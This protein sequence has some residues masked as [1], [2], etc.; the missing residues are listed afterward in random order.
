MKRERVSP[1]ALLIA[2]SLALLDSEPA[3]EG[4]MPP[5][6]GEWSRRFIAAVEG[7]RS[8]FLRLIRRAP[9]RAVLRWIEQ[10]VLPGIGLHYVRRK[11]LIERIVRC[12]IAD[13]C[14]HVVVLAGGFDSLVQRIAREYPSVEFVEVDRPATQAAKRYAIG[15]DFQGNVRYVSTELSCHPEALDQAVPATCSR[16]LILAEAVLMYIPSPAAES[17]LDPFTSRRCNVRIAFTYMAPR[18]QSRIGFAEGGL[19]AD[20]FLAL[21]GEPMRWSATPPD[22]AAALHRRGFAI[23]CDQDISEFQIPGTRGEARFAAPL[24]GERLCIA[25]RGDSSGYGWTEL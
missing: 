8:G 21:R 25:Q 9:L 4:L 12:A 7:P 14:S 10:L 3:T 15:E 1:T 24:H 16:A 5:A 19:P 17:L 6:A 11:H 20:L 23:S 2:R 22:I 13:G 18:R